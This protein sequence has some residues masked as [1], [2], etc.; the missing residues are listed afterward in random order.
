MDELEGEVFPSRFNLKVGSG[1][2]QPPT[3][4]REDLN[5]ERRFTH[6]IAAGHVQQGH[7]CLRP[8]PSIGRHIEEEPNHL[9]CVDGQGG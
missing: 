9:R 4:D 2:V 3:R 5:D 7:L 6:D 1:E 8:S